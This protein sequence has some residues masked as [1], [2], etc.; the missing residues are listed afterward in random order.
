MKKNSGITLIA[1]VITIIVLLILAGV[2]IAM[3][4]GNGGILGKTSK[5]KVENQIGE[6]KDK[7]A[8]DVTKAVSDYYEDAY[9]KDLSVTTTIAAA[10]TGVTDT[11]VANLDIDRYIYEKIKNDFGAENAATGNY[12]IAN[13]AGSSA[14]LESRTADTNNKT[15]FQIQITITPKDTSVNKADT[16]YGII[17]NGVITWNTAKGTAWVEAE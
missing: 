5:A 7:I 14:T 10:Q 1:L 13:V 15:K 6:I 11:T 9:V 17:E 12:R 2:A 16:Y 3:I 8:L 4:T